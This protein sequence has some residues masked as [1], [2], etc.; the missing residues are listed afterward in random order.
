MTLVLASDWS[1]YCEGP[2]LFVL[3]QGVRSSP[4]EAQVAHFEMIILTDFDV[5]KSGQSV[6]IFSV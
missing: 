6:F 1:G 5:E 3:N 4:F 2:G